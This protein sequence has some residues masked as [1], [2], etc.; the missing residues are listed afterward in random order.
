MKQIFLG[1]LK[2]LSPLI[3]I[4]IHFSKQVKMKK[5][6]FN[7]IILLYFSNGRLSELSDGISYG[8]TKTAAELGVKQ[9]LLV[10]QG[11]SLELIK[12]CLC[13]MQK[14]YSPLKKLQNFLAAS[15]AIYNFVRSFTKSIAVNNH[16]S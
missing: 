1:I 10:P 5:V 9:G 3:R 2:I 12:N 16:Q 14:S 6:L 11:N 15:S 13:R 7:K 4:Q 8:R